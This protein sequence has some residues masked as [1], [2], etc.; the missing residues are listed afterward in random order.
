MLDGL[1]MF[2]QSD[3]RKRGSRAWVAF[4]TIV[5]IA[6]AGSAV[7]QTNDRKNDVTGTVSK[8]VP[9][10]RQDGTSARP[11]ADASQCSPKTDLVFWL[12]NDRAIPSIPPG[13]SVCFVGDKSSNDSGPSLEVRDR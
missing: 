6:M 13:I 12:R 3:G 10:L 5:S 11:Y 4:L 7:G 2:E 9:P 8:A 1:K